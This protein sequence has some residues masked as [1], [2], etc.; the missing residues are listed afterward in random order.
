M[1]GNLGSEL[2]DRRYNAIITVMAKSLY[3]FKTALHPLPTNSSFYYDINHIHTT[4]VTGS[5]S[6]SWINSLSASNSTPAIFYILLSFTS[7]CFLKNIFLAAVFDGGCSFPTPIWAR[8][9]T[10]TSLLDGRTPLLLHWNDTQ[11]TGPTI[12]FWF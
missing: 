11:P 2:Q 5:P 6:P 8:S 12:Y 9:S 1:F 3:P 7:L 4:M 10:G